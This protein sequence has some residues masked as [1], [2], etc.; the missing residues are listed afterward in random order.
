[1]YPNVAI[2]LNNNDTIVDILWNVS[3]R[4]LSYDDVAFFENPNFETKSRRL[5]L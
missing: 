5:S 4:F 3:L 1:M 2:V